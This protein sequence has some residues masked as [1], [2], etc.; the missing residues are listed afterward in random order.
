MP[1]PVTAAI[2]ALVLG[3]FPA[4][5]VAGTGPWNGLEPSLPAQECA[6]IAAAILALADAPGGPA[7]G[8]RLSAWALPTWRIRMNYLPPGLW[9]PS[10]AA[11]LASCAAVRAAA[12]RRG[13]RLVRLTLAQQQARDPRPLHWISRA[14]IN[15]GAGTATVEYDGEIAVRLRRSPSGAWKPEPLLPIGDPLM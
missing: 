1:V 10:D 4:D 6:V 2:A 9:R 14:D 7:R 3:A 11:P 15:D 13:W 8:A 5:Q 12:R